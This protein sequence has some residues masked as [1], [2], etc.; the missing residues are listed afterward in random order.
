MSSQL[1]NI[2]NNRKNKG[3]KKKKLN[4]G[5]KLNYGRRKDKNFKKVIPF[6]F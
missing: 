4:I 1:L 2:K 3:K 6:L 5:I